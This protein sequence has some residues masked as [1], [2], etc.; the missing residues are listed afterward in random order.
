MGS[1]SDQYYWAQLVGKRMVV[2]SELP[3]A[4]KTKEDAIKRLTG[5]MTIT[6]RHPGE[7]PFTFESTAKLWIGTNHRPVVSDEAMWRRIRAIPFGQVPEKPDPELKG[8]LCDPE[9]GLPA[10]LSWAVEGAVRLLGSGSRDAL[11]W[12]SAVADATAAYRKSEDR[13]GAF[14]EEET[15]AG[16]GLEVELGALYVAYRGWAD[17]RGEKPMTMISL[18]RKLTE[19][20]ESV[21]GS[22]GRSTVSGRAIKPRVAAGIGALALRGG[23]Y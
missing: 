20:G 4:R 10:A 2:F 18:Q 15:R 5:D 19:R 9:G 6:G 12:C 23:A 11:G 13:V 8:F 1:G 17:A 7:R 22:G 16:A 21:T 14:L 3:E